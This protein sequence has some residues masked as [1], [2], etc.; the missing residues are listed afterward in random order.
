MDL[1]IGVGWLE[2]EFD[3]AGQDFHNRGRRMDELIQVLKLLWTE[4][5]PEFHG[6][7]YDFPPVRFDPK[8]V[9]KPHPRILVGGESEAAMRRAA[10]LGD[11]WSTAGIHYTIES[12]AEAVRKVR[13]Y[14]QEYGRENEPFDVY[15]G[16]FGW[17]DLDT[18][19]RYQEI[20]VDSIRVTPWAGDVSRDAQQRL[21]GAGALQQA[22]RTP[23]L[24]D[25]IIESLERYAEEVLS[26]LDREP[27][28]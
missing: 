13:G 23:N 16:S 14:A 7:Y 11:G 24:R 12:A 22:S 4:D 27:A 9:Q 15:C 28:R 3:L 20:G 5:E 8:P 19:R 6:R 17:A 1:G 2:E 18:I 25:R 21:G 26:K 10:R